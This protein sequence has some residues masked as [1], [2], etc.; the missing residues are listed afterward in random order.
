MENIHLN[1]MSLQELSEYANFAEWQVEKT[2]RRLKDHLERLQQRN[3]EGIEISNAEEKIARAAQDLVHYYEKC[4]EDL[5]NAMRKKF[6]SVFPQDEI[7][8]IAESIIK[9]M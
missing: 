7:D 4:F 6:R 2:K 8:K 5:E 3:K 9:K 1:T